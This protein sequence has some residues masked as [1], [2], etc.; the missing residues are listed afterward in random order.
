MSSY[1]YTCDYI[2]YQYV[3]TSSLKLWHMASFEFFK[4]FWQTI[5]FIYFNHLIKVTKLYHVVAYDCATWQLKI[6]L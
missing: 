6:A 2:A 5:F 4:I 3:H 1:D